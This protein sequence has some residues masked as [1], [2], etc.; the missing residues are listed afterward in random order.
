MVVVILKSTQPAWLVWLSWQECGPINASIAVLIPGQ[1][2]CLGFQSGPQ[3]G[4]MGEAIRVS[5][6]CFSLTSMFPFHT[7][8][9]SL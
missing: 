2:T 8:F 6:P 4:C 3:S 5:H 7:P 1:G 9:P